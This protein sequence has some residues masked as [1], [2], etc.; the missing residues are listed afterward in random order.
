VLDSIGALET[1]LNKSGASEIG[2]AR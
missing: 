1:R 2:A